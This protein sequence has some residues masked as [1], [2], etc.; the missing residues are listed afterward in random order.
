MALKP[1]GGKYEG[2]WVNELKNGD[3]SYYINYRDES[4]KPKRVLVGKKTKQSDFTVKDAYAKLIEVKYKLQHGQ[5]PV[6]KGGR[7]TK[8]KLDDLFEQ[9]IKWAKANKKSWRDDERRYNKHIKP[10]LGLRAVKTLK[11]QDFEAL[12]QELINKGLS[13][14][15]TKHCLA[16]CRQMINYAIRNELIH[17]YA[18]PIAAGRVKLPELDNSRLA[19]LTKEQGRELLEILKATNRAAYQLTGLLLLTGARFSEVASLSWM[20]VNEHTGMIHFKKSKRGNARHI[21]IAD[22]LAEILDE[23][24]EQKIAENDLIIKTQ[25]GNQYERMPKAFETAIEKILPGNA[26]QDAKHKITAHSLRHTHASWLAMDGLDILQIKEQLGH[27]TIE[28]TMRY[29]HLIP[30]RR[31]EATGNLL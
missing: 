20:D 11:S 19:F 1:V 5:E 30:N 14:A 29:A 12:K 9:Y 17:N 7:I 10:L 15:T 25:Y 22:M 18:N 23:L 26:N 6:V 8:V 2:V 24:R 28:M 21:L 27:K 31:H 3:I 16:I 4:G 13:P